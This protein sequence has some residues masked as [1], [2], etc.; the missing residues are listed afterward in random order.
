VAPGVIMKA[1][2]FGGTIPGLVLHVRQGDTVDFTLVNHGSTPHSIDFH[3]AQTPWDKNYQSINPGQSLSFI[4][5]ADCPGVFMYYC[6]TPPVIHH[7]ASGIY[8]AIVVDAAQLLPVAKEY[9]LV[10]SELYLTQ[11][12]AGYYYT[13]GE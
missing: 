2:T 1:W 8:G 6:G 13:D 12:A 10:R 3:A 9:V 7:I 5:T 11:Q 4:W